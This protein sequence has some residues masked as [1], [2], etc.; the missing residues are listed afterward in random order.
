MIKTTRPATNNNTVPHIGTIENILHHT[1]NNS[2]LIRSNKYETTKTAAHNK[3]E[4]INRSNENTFVI[5][6]TP[7]NSSNKYK[8]Q[9]IT[10]NP[11]TYRKPIINNNITNN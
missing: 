7:H 2:N 4:K 3:N 11:K 1:D 5:H 6:S 10:N 8:N 9:I